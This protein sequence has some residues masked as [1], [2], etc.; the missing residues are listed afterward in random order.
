[1]MKVQALILVVLATAASAA[2]EYPEEWHLWKAQHGVTY[3]VS[4]CSHNLL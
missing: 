4:H 2:V 1:M 3:T